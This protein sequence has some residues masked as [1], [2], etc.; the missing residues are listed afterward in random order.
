MDIIQCKGNPWF[1]FNPSF[2]EGNCQFPLFPGRG[3]PRDY[4][5][6]FRIVD[7]FIVLRHLF[8]KSE[9]LFRVLTFP[10]HSFLDTF[11]RYY[12]N[13]MLF[14]WLIVTGLA[15]NVCEINSSVSF[16][17][18]LA[19]SNINRLSSWLSIINLFTIVYI[20]SS[21]GVVGVSSTTLGGGG[22]PLQ[23]FLWVCNP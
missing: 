22:I 5:E 12:I 18:S 8:D 23:S 9:L 10:H 6:Q 7:C 17:C 1:P 11:I 13:C 3:F 15:T 20:D 4:M 2:R 19:W 21:D 14:V 16:L